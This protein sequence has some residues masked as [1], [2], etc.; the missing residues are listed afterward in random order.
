MVADWIKDTIDKYLC[1]DAKKRRR[2]RGFLG[3]VY[4]IDCLIED[5]DDGGDP[6]E[7]LGELKKINHLFGSLISHI[8]FYFIFSF[9]STFLIL[10]TIPFYSIFFQLFFQLSKFLYNIFKSPPFIPPR[11]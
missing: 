10:Q 8:P 7:W 6:L 5:E 3:L 1:L 11:N 4:E 2:W 9:F